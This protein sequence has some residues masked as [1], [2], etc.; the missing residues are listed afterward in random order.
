MALT[1]SE[2]RKRNAIMLLNM[3]AVLAATSAKGG[4]VARVTES[5][6]FRVTESGES[7]VTE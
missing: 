3:A 6:E 1:P 7:R 2:R 4:S 5:G